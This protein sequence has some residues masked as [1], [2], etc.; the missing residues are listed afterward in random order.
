MYSRPKPGPLF[1]FLYHS[2]NIHLLYDIIRAFFFLSFFVFSFC[3]DTFGGQSSGV[4]ILPMRFISSF[5]LRALRFSCCFFFPLF[6]FPRR[7][8]LCFLFLL[9]FSFF[10]IFAIAIYSCFVS[11]AAG[12]GAG[13]IHT[14]TH[15][16]TPRRRHTPNGHPLRCSFRWREGKESSPH[17]GQRGAEGYVLSIESARFAFG[18]SCSFSSLRLRRSTCTVL[19]FLFFFPF[20]LCC[21]CA[22]V[23]AVCGV[24]C[25]YWLQEGVRVFVSVDGRGRKGGGGCKRAG[26]SGGRVGPAEEGNLHSICPDGNTC[27]PPLCLLPAFWSRRE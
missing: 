23:C 22:C 1:T 6:F 3:H 27:C 25:A 10:F 9:S 5:C 14:P 15:P 17:D 11:L 12:G 8:S 24:S 2:A 18:S 26:R 4:L 20:F 19:S 7:S 21:V 13:R 16:H